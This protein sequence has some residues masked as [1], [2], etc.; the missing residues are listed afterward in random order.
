VKALEAGYAF[1]IGR[2]ADEDL[3]AAVGEIVEGSAPSG[4]LVR[5]VRTMQEPPATALDCLSE[6]PPTSA[7]SR[8]R[9]N[10]PV[11]RG[12]DFGSQDT[13]E[14]EIDHGSQSGYE[15]TT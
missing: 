13:T 10:G 5:C 14:T 6:A 7:P 11:R 4:Y 9:A 8:F 3:A 15:S 12:R 2:G 1:L